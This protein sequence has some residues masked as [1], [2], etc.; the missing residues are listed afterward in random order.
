MDDRSRIG[1]GGDGLWERNHPSMVDDKVDPENSNLES[2]N[3]V[4]RPHSAIA[5]TGI[6]LR[7]VLLL[8]RFARSQQEGSQYLHIER[9]LCHKDTN[10]LFQLCYKFNSG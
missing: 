3:I 1:V 10:K 8:A 5:K 7:L 6:S 9:V 2:H 4:P